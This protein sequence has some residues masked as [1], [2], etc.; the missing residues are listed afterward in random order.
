MP[1]CGSPKLIAA[2]HVFLRLL[3]PRHPPCALSSLTIKFTRHTV[4][5]RHRR[6][7]FGRSLL[8]HLPTR[9]A[10]PTGLDSCSSRIPQF[11]LL[12]RMRCAPAGT[13]G[14]HKIFTRLVICPIYSVVKY[15]P[16][17]LSLATRLSRYEQSLNPSIYKADGLSFQLNVRH[18][19]LLA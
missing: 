12:T 10:N 4:R 17:Q 3:L 13:S 2:C 15:R 5:L 18:Q 7:A 11:S 9:R 6:P 8:A 16:R 14:T 1:A 19:A